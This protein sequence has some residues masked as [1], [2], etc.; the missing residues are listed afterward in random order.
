MDCLKLFTKDEQLGK[1]DPW[2]C[3]E[4][5]E[6]RQAFKKFD[7]WT[8]PPILII[9]LK[10][11]SYRNS[12]R[13]KLEQF[14]QFPL[15]N[16]DISD[17][18]IGPKESNAIY[19]LYA[20]SNHIGA[21]SHGHYTAFARVRDDGKWYCYDDQSVKEIQAPNVCS[22]NA[23]VLFYK[24]RDIPW[25]VFD[26]TLDKLAT[27]KEEEGGD[28]ED[29]DDT[30]IRIENSS[31]E[32]NPTTRQENSSLEVNPSTSQGNS[33]VIYTVDVN[34]PQ[35]QENSSLEVNPTIRQENSSLEVSPNTRLE[36]T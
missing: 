5:K 31:L 10:R 12:W 32:L 27:Q 8:A 4:C 16:L 11:F 9:H 1:D 7:I 29:S 19:D 17:F 15:E 14:I 33:E 22:A 30:P 28:E 34:P 6:F 21:I 20:V 26:Q 36:N 25:L 2:Y 3:S 13:E 35:T 23:Y 18:V 24:R